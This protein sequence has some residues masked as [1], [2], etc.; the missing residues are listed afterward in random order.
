MTA[1]A[2]LHL[3]EDERADLARFLAAV[4]TGADD[5]AVEKPKRVVSRRTLREAA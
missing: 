1:G 5:A 2:G 4:I 3:D